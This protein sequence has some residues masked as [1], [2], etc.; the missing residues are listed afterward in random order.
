MIKENAP[1]N[2]PCHHT[3]SFT[4]VSDCEPNI[5]LEGAWGTGHHGGVHQVSVDPR[6]QDVSPPSYHQHH[7]DKDFDHSLH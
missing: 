7:R 3:I 2:Q 4:F 1:T 5:S 6:Q